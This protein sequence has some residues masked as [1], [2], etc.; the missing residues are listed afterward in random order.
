M[1]L[2]VYDDGCISVYQHF[3]VFPTIITSEELSFNSPFYSLLFSIIIYCYSVM[4]LLI[5]QFCTS[6]FCSSENTLIFS[7]VNSFTFAF[8]EG[9][10]CTSIVTSASMYKHNCVYKKNK[11]NH[12]LKNTTMS[13][14]K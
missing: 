14:G 6:E 8:L 4:M 2:K 12:R 5:N 7:V 3:F 1:I 9:K 11:L 13:P 10:S